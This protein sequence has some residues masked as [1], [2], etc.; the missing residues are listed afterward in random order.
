MSDTLSRLW[1]GLQ[2]VI[3]YPLID[4][5]ENHLTLNSILKLLALLALVLLAGRYLRRLL[6]RRVLA[7]TQLSPD[8]QYAVS[9]FA[10]YCFI[11]IGFFFAF[12]VVHLDLSSLAVIVGA[13]GIGIGFGLQNVVSNF[14]SGLIILAERPIAIGHRI[15]VGSVAG[16]VTKINLRSTTVVTNDNITIIVPNSNFITNAV[17]NWSYGDPKVRLRLPVGVAYGSDVAKLR[18]LLLAV[19]AENSAVLAQPLPSVRFLGFGDSALNF[20]LAVWTIELAQSP[21][22]FRSD[23]YFAI[24]RKLRENK[25]EIPFPQRDLHLRSGN[26]TLVAPPSQPLGGGAVERKPPSAPA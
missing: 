18:T 2:T 19:A 1:A 17:T 13:L 21:T 20:E 15:E 8:L 14:I 23:L 24:E 11:A 9:R 5:G 7:R 10:G 3:N 6:R 25:I 26:F 16:Q 4:L 12:K 22:R